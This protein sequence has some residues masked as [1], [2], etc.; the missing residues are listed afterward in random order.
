M[1][2]RLLSIFSILLMSFSILAHN[3]EPLHVDGRYL[4]NPNG[5]I[6]TL[7]GYVV[8]LDSW[9]QAEDFKFENYDF[10]AAIINKKAAPLLTLP[11]LVLLGRL[12]SLM[13]AVRS[14]ITWSQT[15]ASVLRVSLASSVPTFSV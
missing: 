15:W 7:H 14:E 9:F 11:S 5:D 4:K 8:S 6:V 2:A 1:K 12:G 13:Q 10:Q 3:L